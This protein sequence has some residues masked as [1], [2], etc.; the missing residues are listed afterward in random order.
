MAISIVGKFPILTLKKSQTDEFGFDYVSYQY[1]VETSKLGSYVVKKDDKFYGFN[2]EGVV[3]TIN[4]SS[5]SSSYVVDSVENRDI[6]GG[7]TELTISTVGTKNSVQSNTPR[8]CLLSG[9]PLIFGLSGTVQP[10]AIYGYGVAGVGQSV[11]VKFLAE[12]GASGQQDVFTTHFASQMPVS[13]RGVFLPVPA[14][15]PHIFSNVEYPA[16]NFSPIGQDGVYYGF[17]CKTI[18]TEKRGSLL[19]VTLTFS[20]A[21]TASQYTDTGG[22]FQYSFPPIG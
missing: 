13:F 12:G 10:Y 3:I 22:Y 6:A 5:S 4:T 2:S 11:E 19:L 15:E 18:I 14:R 1:T 8:V 16:P 9:G 20:E 17:V 21:G 7:L